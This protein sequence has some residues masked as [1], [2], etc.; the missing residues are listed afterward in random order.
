MRC[1]MICSKSSEVCNS[2]AKITLLQHRT[3]LKQLTRGELAQYLEPIF[4]ENVLLPI[5]VMCERASEEY[6]YWSEE[7]QT[8]ESELSQVISELE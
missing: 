4:F 3:F 5:T 2:S 7:T 8:L 1:A 6:L